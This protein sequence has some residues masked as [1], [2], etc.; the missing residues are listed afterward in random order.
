MSNISFAASGA[1]S[2]YA[3]A[4]VHA[5]VKVPSP[6]PA[7]LTVLVSGLTASISLTEART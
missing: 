6:D 1:F 3:L 4:N 7:Y 5:V 2:E